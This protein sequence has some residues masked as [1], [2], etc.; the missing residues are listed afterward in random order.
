MFIFKPLNRKPQFYSMKKSLLFIGLSLLVFCCKSK[1]I[2]LSGN[3][4]VSKKDF[5]SFFETLKLPYQLTDDSLEEKETDTDEI[6]NHIFLQHVPDSILNK[7]FGKSPKPKLFALGKVKVQ[8][9]ESYLFVKAI[10]STRKIG[11]VLCFDKDDNFVV[12]K[13]LIITDNHSAISSV[14]VMDAKYTITIIRQHTDASGRLL[15][16]KS[17]FVFNNAGAFALILTESNETDK[18]G[19]PIINPID[20]LAHK[21]KFTGDYA[22]DKRNYISVR[23][24]KDQA[25]IVFFVHFEKDKG[26]CKGELKGIARFVSGNIAQYRANSDPCTVE[27]SFGSTGVSMKELDGCGNHRDIK[28]FFE[29]FY[30]K[31]KEPKTKAAKK[32]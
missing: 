20:T 30:A 7:Y 1:R 27:F 11:Y 19:L 12:A 24:G 17:A 14:V 10:T 21:H 6:S 9:Q 32:K 13:P 8:K 23:D 2:S 26:E 29:G 15:Y 25:H 18:E 31:R 4:K 22:Q 28:C 3:E 16:K 5:V